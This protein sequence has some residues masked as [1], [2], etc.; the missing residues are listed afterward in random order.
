MKRVTG[1]FE[2]EKLDLVETQRDN[3]PVNYLYI[4]Q[5]HDSIKMRVR[6]N[7]LL[8]AIKAIPNRK[9]IKLKALVQTYK[10]E[11]Y[12]QATSLIE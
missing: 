9:P 10:D 8:N 3:K 1:I 2:G 4:L 11:I 5:G 6:N 7:T 12:L